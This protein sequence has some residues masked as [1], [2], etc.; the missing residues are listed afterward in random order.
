MLFIRPKRGS[1]LVSYLVLM[2]RRSARLQNLKDG[3]L[4]DTVSECGYRDRAWVFA[5]CQAYLLVFE[6]T[7]HFVELEAVFT[8]L[9]T[10]RAQVCLVFVLEL[11][12]LAANVVIGRI[13]STTFYVPPSRKKVV[14]ATHLIK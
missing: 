5:R 3:A 8:K 13:Q 10:Y 11:G 4:H 1:I 2:S 7:R 14:F 6:N 9:P 12:G